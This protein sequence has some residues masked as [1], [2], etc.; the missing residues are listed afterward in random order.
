M[1]SERKEGIYERKEGKEERK[2]KKNEEVVV[3]EEDE[4]MASSA[5]RSANK[6]A[7]SV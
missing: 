7:F 2:E 3:E 5:L 6:V 4:A 1:E